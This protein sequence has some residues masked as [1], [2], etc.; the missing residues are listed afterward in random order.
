VRNLC[1]LLFLLGL[2]AVAETTVD[3]ANLAQREAW[4]S[5]P[6]YGDA[7]FDSFIHHPKNPI[8]RGAGAGVVL[9]FGKSSSSVVIGFHLEET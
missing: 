5:H 8:H 6:V 1:V 2:P 3:Y 4:L 9:T 7:S